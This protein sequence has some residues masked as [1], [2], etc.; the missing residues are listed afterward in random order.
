ME[1]SGEDMGSEE[2]VQMALSLARANSEIQE[3]RNM[4]E[5]RL[6]RL[7]EMEIMYESQL[8]VLR[9]ALENTPLRCL[10]ALRKAQENNEALMKKLAEVEQTNL[11]LEAENVL[12]RK[13]TE[14]LEAERKLFLQTQ[15]STP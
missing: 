10:N 4:A 8:V 1:T 11:T 15:P 13:R 2:L 6:V 12:L 7:A 9:K 14:L 5:H 3:W